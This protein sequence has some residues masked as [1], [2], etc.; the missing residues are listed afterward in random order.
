MWRLG[1][2]ELCEGERRLE[3]IK[4]D[5]ENYVL[6][7]KS[8]KDDTAEG[9]YWPKTFGEKEELRKNISKGN[10]PEKWKW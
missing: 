7:M 10:H 8:N 9:K 2:N 4:E 6:V 5:D 1:E 3:Q